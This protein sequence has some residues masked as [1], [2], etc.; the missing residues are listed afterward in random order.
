MVVQTADQIVIDA[1]KICDI[2]PKPKLLKFRGNRNVSVKE[3][4]EINR[5]VGWARAVA[6]PRAILVFEEALYCQ[7]GRGRP[8]SVLD[9]L[10]RYS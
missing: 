1:A 7:W 9:S 10:L 5:G 8:N 2:L 6:M 4:D 3:A